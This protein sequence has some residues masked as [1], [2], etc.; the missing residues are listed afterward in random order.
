MPAPRGRAAI[1]HPIVK[2]L[3]LVLVIRLATAGLAFVSNVVFPLHQTQGFSVY[4]QPHALL[5]TFA[6]YDAGWYHGIARSGY[7][8]VEDGRSNLA[9]FPVYPLAM[10]AAGH[11]LGG[12]PSD[13]YLGGVLVSWLASAGAMVMLY[14]L[15]RL[16]MDEAAAERGVV[17]ALLHPGAF[18]LGVVYTESTYLL[19][20][21]TAMY[22]FRTGHWWAGGAAGAL[23]TATRVTGIML[24]PALAWAAWRTWTET[25]SSPWWMPALAVAMVPLGLVAF[26]AWCYMLSG[27]PLEWMASITRWNYQPGGH[28]LSALSALATELGT[29][30]YH[31]L[32]HTPAA[33]YD[34]LNGLL[35]IAALAMTPLVWWRFGTAYALVILC[36]LALPLSSG[37]Y[38]GLTR[39]TSVLYPLALLLGTI[40]S[41]LAS[42]LLIG[43]SGALY[44]L[45]LALFTNV[46][47]LF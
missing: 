10:R 28:P 33:P 22:G 25:R 17:F 42:G 2:V 4:R 7:A 11:L 12:L 34:T 29:R 38:E 36:S 19:L 14:R 18:F 31:Y 26:S 30:P 15:A 23:L 6:R 21:V 43:L 20:A 47:P 9:F 35:A 37:Q 39:Y 40:R 32:V 46:H 16:D 1:G 45:C 5:D 27:N 41:P 24:L 8:W 13:F 44:M 3:F